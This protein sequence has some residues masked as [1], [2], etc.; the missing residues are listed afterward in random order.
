M[1]D[2]LVVDNCWTNVDESRAAMWR[3]LSEM[4]IETARATYNYIELKVE[5][6]RSEDI[7]VGHARI[8]ILVDSIPQ[9]AEWSENTPPILKGVVAE[10]SKTLTGRKN[11]NLEVLSFAENFMANFVIFMNSD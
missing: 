2:D 5:G 8:H 3:P 11:L 10:N 4:D 6:F 7:C 1:V 9:A